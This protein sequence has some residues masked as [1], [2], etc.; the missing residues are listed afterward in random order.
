MKC[1]REL[2]DSQI[3]E[4]GLCDTEAMSG[5]L[6]SSTCLVYGVGISD[7]W[8]FEMA[9]AKKGCE[10]HAFDPTIDK[11]P[12]DESETLPNLHFHRW[13]LAGETK[14]TGSHKVAGT[15]S[16]ATET[17]QPML[18]L[19]DMMDRLGHSKRRISV[20]KIDCE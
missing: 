19:A 6:L 8:D 10:V 13:G 4:H 15:K 18:T 12:S 16:G 3:G 9:M 17:S 11:P 5:D 2:A 20:F 7:N 14:E 1:P